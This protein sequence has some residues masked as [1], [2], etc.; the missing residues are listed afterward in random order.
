MPRITRE[1]QKDFPEIYAD[2]AIPMK[3]SKLRAKQSLVY[4]I[5]LR[6]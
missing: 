2:V 6:K 1:L 4:S 3:S 5:F